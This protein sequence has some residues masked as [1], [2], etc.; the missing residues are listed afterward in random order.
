M[1]SINDLNLGT[2]FRL[3]RKQTEIEARMQVFIV[4]YV[5]FVL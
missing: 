4:N 3:K 2:I 1:C 5:Y